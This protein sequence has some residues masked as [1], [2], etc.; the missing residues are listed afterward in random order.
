MTTLQEF[1]LARIDEDER[2]A[3]A[4]PAGPWSVEAIDEGGPIEYAVFAPPPP[5]GTVR[6]DQGEPDDSVWVVSDEREEVVAHIAAFDPTR[7]LAECEAKRRI[8][9][10]WMAGRDGDDSGF[11]TRRL[12]AALALPYAD[13]PDYDETWRDETWRP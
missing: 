3:R 10:W 9:E 11:D 2:V 5:L 6:D 7:V 4:G 1:L 8:I 13:H 12:L